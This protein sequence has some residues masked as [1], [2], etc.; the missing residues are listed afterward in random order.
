MAI[1]L[2]MLKCFATVARYGSLSE[3][4]QALGRTPSA[5]SM[6]L[7]QFED[8]IGAP[9][10]ETSRKSRLTALGALIYDEARREVSHFDSTID[11]IE[12]LSRARVGHVR[13]AVTPSV[14]T[15]LMPR[16]IRSFRAA[17]PKVQLDLRDMDSVSM[18]DELQRDRVDI[19]VATLP[20]IDGMIRVE[21]FRDGFGLVCRADDALAQKGASVQWSDL[22]AHRLIANGLCDQ[23]TDPE[24]APIL[25][26]ST[27]RVANTS[28]LLGLVREGVG[29]TILPRLALSGF[30]P[31]LAFVPLV[32]LAS[33]RV[34]HMVHP[35]PELLLPAGRAFVDAIKTA[36]QA[37]IVQKS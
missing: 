34:V 23:I 19:A 16:V 1:K 22:D 5:V 17:H 33:Q 8:H 12:G 6:M 32:Q 15:T 11:V 20:R 18:A 35:R 10:F 7:K 13:V 31:D 21:V 30:G 3:A 26:G 36:I 28:S 37:Q 24:F 25:A 14:A 29:V 27:L 9:L 4:A 2:D